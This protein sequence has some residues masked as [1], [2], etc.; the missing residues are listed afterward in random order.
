MIV[1]EV[2]LMHLSSSLSLQSRSHLKSTA[3]LKKYRFFNW[4]PGFFERHAVLEDTG[5]TGIYRQYVRIS[6]VRSEIA[7][8]ISAKSGTWRPVAGS[9][10]LL[11]NRLAIWWPWLAMKP[12][13]NLSDSFLSGSS[14]IS[15]VIMA[16]CW[17]IQI[18]GRNANHNFHWDGD[19]SKPW[20]P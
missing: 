10:T 14:L 6:K 12:I 17:F 8:R 20:Y 3:L 4:K 15:R 11:C 1:W 9:T 13:G 18:S 19:G 2:L 5:D 16:T 7:G